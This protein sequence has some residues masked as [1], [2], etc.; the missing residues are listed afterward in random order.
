MAASLSTVTNAA[1]ARTPS[2]EN[3]LRAQNEELRKLVLDLKSRLPSV[4]NAS[5]PY[6]QIVSGNAQEA[7]A[8][9]AHQ[10]DIQYITDIILQTVLTALSSQ[11]GGGG[12]DTLSSGKG[13]GITTT[14][15]WELPTIAG[16][17]GRLNKT[18][19]FKFD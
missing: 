19:V 9:K 3:E 11:F 1:A 12:R 8:E 14:T 10:T 17:S 7:P 4:E 6:S 16:K 13:T 15:K 5:K 2:T 18:G